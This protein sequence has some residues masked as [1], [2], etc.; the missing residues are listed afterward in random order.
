MEDT[1][2]NSEM[3]DQGHNRAFTEAFEAH[4]DELFRHA[5]MRLNGRERAVELVQ[6]A[7]LRTW[8]F[9][10]GGGEVRQYRPF[11]YRTL[12]NLIID[13][14]RKH[15]TVSLDAML[16]HEE[17]TTAVEGALLADSADELEEALLRFESQA[18]LAALEQLPEGYRAVV[19]LRYIDGLSPTE[20]AEVLGEKENTISVRIH[21]GLHKLRALLEP[22]E[23]NK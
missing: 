8:R 1:N 15:Q 6:E 20:I 21:R 9:V 3:G 19:V 16:E 13:E 7:F 14:Y 18:A 4:S 11:L 10:Q 23:E 12:N 17:T 2:R 5:S 22:S